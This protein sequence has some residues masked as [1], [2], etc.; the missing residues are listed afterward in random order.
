MYKLLLEMY[1]R[2]PTVFLD[3]DH[4]L[5]CAYK[6]GSPD[7]M[8]AQ[9]ENLFEPA[10]TF[11][12]YDVYTR[13]HLTEFLDFLFK[14]F[15]VAIW[16]AASSDYAAVITSELVL[17][18]DKTRRLDMFLTADDT[19]VASK[20]MGGVKNLSA[21]WSVWYADHLIPRNWAFIV[22]DLP[23]VQKTQPD[24][25]I[26][27]EPF[28]ASSVRAPED[29]VLLDTIKK[30]KEKLLDETFNKYSSPTPQQQQQPPDDAS[31]N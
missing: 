15:Y 14:N 16:T 10:V 29:T 27:V 6:Q 8:K 7:S 22:D 11:A 26:A 20:E 19:T 12:N 30:L 18:D 28:H 21:I 17:R 24:K 23:D 25:C 13:P 5:I 1:R 2:K 4:T 31:F 9:T 3:L